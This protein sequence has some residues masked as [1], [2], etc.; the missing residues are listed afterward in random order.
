MKQYIILVICTFLL[1]CNREE[2][3]VINPT[4]LEEIKSHIKYVNNDVNKKAKIKIL[5]CVH[6]KALFDTSLITIEYVRY[7]DFLNIILKGYEPS[8]KILSD[9]IA[10][11]GFDSR[12]MLTK[13]KEN[14]DDYLFEFIPDESELKYLTSE[15]Y[16]VELLFVKG[17]FIKTRVSNDQVNPFWQAFEYYNPPPKKEFNYGKK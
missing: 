16:P 9:T 6:E 4:I 3:K 10:I 15:Y 5:I 11:V 2:K 1:S 12:T 17:K 7:K 8:W 13:R 14:T